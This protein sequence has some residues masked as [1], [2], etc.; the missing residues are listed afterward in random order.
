[1]TGAPCSTAHWMPLKIMSE[2]PSL[3]VQDLSNK[4]LGYP[5]SNSDPLTFYVA[6]ENC[7]RAVG[8]VPLPVA[9]AGGSKIVLDNGI[10]HPGKCRMALVDPGIQHRD[11]HAIPG[12]A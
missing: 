7:T 4:S 2:L 3:L 10:L 11:F 9:I 5:R 1:M 12:K 8:A 6:A